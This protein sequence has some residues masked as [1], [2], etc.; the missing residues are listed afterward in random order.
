MAALHK[1]KLKLTGD[2]PCDLRFRSAGPAPTLGADAF[3]QPAE[4]IVHCRRPRAN[5]SNGSTEA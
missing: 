2:V 1:R 3:E 5:F 4:V